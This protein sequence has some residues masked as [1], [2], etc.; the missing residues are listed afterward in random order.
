MRAL[1]LSAGL[2]TRLRPLTEK[3]PKPLVLINGKPLLLYH[4][5]SL[6][7]YG[8]RNILI[9]THY[10][11]E[12][13]ETFVKENKNLFKGLTIETIFEKN[14]LGSAG[15]LKKNS[16]FFQEED[17]LIVYGD[18]LTMISYEKLTELHRLKKGIVT[19]ASYWEEKPETKG[20]IVFDEN[21]KISQFI[22]KPK[23]EQVVS[24]FANAGIYVVNKK[25]FEYLD[26][27]DQTPLDFGFHIFPFLLEK[28]VEMYVYE[29]DEFLLDIGTIESYTKAQELIKLL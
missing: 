5:E 7:K 12:Q 21:K 20:I 10:L 17:F 27:L 26:V 13:V 2:G 3:T 1:I 14:L 11:S 4:L 9:N 22:E 16:L 19:I 18:N 25:I 8:I 23:I 28:K 15:T 29:M 6:Y 24:N